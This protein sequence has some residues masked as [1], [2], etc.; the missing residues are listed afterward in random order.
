M[1][2]ED[3]YILPPNIHTQV[4]SKGSYLFLEQKAGLSLETILS[5]AVMLPTAVMFGTDTK[6]G[7]ECYL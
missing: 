3:I 4:S 7:G 2:R 1:N 6:K 5:V